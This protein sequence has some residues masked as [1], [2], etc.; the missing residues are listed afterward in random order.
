MNE[1]NGFLIWH[2]MKIMTQKVTLG[3]GMSFLIEP[4]LAEHSIDLI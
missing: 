2:F 3:T 1:E 4:E